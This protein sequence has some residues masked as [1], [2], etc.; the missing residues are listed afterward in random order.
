M[1]YVFL[2]SATLTFDTELISI[3]KKPTEEILLRVF[4]FFILPVAV[5]CAV[6]FM[7]N[8]FKKDPQQKKRSDGRGGVRARGPKKSN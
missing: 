3:N 7:Y 2:A 1:L 4:R 8:K 5:I 6:F